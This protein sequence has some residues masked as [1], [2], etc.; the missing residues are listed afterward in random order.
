MGIDVAVARGLDSVVLDDLLRVVFGPTSVR[1]V[2]RPDVIRRMDPNVIA[3]DSPPAWGLSGKSRPIESQLQSLGISIFPTPAPEF[4]RE[5]H[6]WMQTGFEVFK[7]A[8]DL[9]YPL[10][11]ASASFARSAIEVFP[12][13]S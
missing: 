1:L 13:A 10:H 4:A 12:H 6:R 2:D 8:A 3:L 7:V 5:L 11:T 9:G